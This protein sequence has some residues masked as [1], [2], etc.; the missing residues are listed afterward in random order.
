M[1][2]IIFIT[3]P[4]NQYINVYNTHDETIAAMADDTKLAVVTTQLHLLS[5]DLIEASFKTILVRHNNKIY[6]CKLGR[7]SWTTKELR[8]E[9]NLYK[10]VFANIINASK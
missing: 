10:L 4:S 8:T 7:N 5:F 2:T 9:H 1:K 3:S 6:E